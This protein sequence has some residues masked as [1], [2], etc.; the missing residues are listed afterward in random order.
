MFFFRN[1][2]DVFYVLFLCT[3]AESILL[4]GIMFRLKIFFL[5]SVFLDDFIL[6]LLQKDMIPL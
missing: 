2:S 3:Y 6:N 4:P 5:L 1:Y